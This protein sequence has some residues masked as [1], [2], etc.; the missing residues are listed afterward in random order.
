MHHLA[1]VP[2]DLSDLCFS[3]ILVWSIRLG[4][5]HSGLSLLALVLPFSIRKLPGIVRDQDLRYTPVLEDFI[6]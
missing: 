3:L 4:G 2:L 5:C 6:Q 1:I